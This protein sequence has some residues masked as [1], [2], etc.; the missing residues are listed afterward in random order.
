MAKA[1]TSSLSSPALPPRPPPRCLFSTS[2]RRPSSR[3]HAHEDEQAH[4]HEHHGRDGDDD[5][6]GTGTD[7]GT[8]AGTDTEKGSTAPGKFLDK[9]TI[10]RLGRQ[11]PAALGGWASEAFF[12]FTIVMSM[13][14]SEYFIGGFNIVLPPIAEALR[15]PAAS[16]TWPAGVTNLTTAALLQPFARLCDLYGGR[17]VFLSGHA[18]LLVWSLVSG[19]SR[20]TTMLIVCRAMQGVGSAAFLPAGLAILS[21]MYRPG[22]RKNVVFAIYGAFACL[23][24]YF[25]IF[26]GALT[27]EFL[28]WRWYFW[29]GAGVGLVVAGSG[30]ASI[31]RDLGDVNP[32]ARMDW[33]GV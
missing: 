19:F 33:L 12:V 15:M 7:A 18:W 23:G 14:M 26:A 29:V 8:D 31:P 1:T 4:P 30:W 27:A 17:A 21:Q 11:R 24:F 5:G 2:S 20:S 25:G 13:M 32:D 3:P 9:A 10:E 6:T 22:P 16:R 28:D